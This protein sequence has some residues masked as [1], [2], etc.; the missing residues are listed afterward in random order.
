MSKKLT[1]PA[2]RR[3]LEIF[4]EDWEFLESE[5]GRYSASRV[6]I[7]EVVRAM[8]HKWVLTLKARAAEAAD[9]RGASRPAQE[10]EKQP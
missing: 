10:Q 4:N 1:L 9:G 6:G 7:S 5:Y 3:H 8:I 2:T